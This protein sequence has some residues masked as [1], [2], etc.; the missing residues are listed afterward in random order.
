MTARDL[1]AIAFGALR[2]HG[3]RTAL[4]VLGVAI[5][6]VSVVLLT[7]IGNGARLYLAGEFAALGTNL[8]IVTPG[9]SETTGLAPMLIGAPHDLT[10]DDAEAIARRVPDVRFVA[11]LAI[12]GVRA[13]HGERS[14]DAVVA[15]VTPAW[16]DVRNVT[17]SAGQ[18]LPG[19]VTERD[20]A[21]CILGATINQA[22]FPGTN[23]LGQTV[24]LGEERC[25]VIGVAAPR[26]T[27]L[28]MDYDVVVQM[29]IRRHMRIFN[30]TSVSRILVEVTSADRVDAV[31]A[32]IA[33]L[34]KER[35]DQQEDVTLLTQDSVM[36][37]LSSI[38]TVLTE[39][40]V[41]I[42]AISLAVAGIGIMNVMLVAVAERTREI[43]LFKALGARPSQILGVFLAEAG[44]LTLLGGLAGL[45]LA[46]GAIW[47]ARLAFPG[48][49]TE[50]PLWAVV[51]ALVLSV[52]VGLL[53]GAWPA[54]RASKL[55]PVVALSRR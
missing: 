35:H 55:D 44:L 42:A 20:Q 21:V 16:R 8:V 23:A 10:L 11:P 26:G 38:L 43:G 48:F 29:P 6:V 19:G 46:F 1:M 24:R 25:L 22:L 31:K 14:H 47:A 50:A 41:G 9:K 39:A 54:R 45:L 34:L 49:P 5:G 27:S 17:L 30:Q 51:S 3:L 12:G 13:S 53:F 33:A 52:V 32:A 36:A 28:G 18:F 4:S 37:G 2:G 40:L 7:S 15:G